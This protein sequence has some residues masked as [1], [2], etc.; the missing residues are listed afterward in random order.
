MG[1]RETGARAALPSWLEAMKGF[2]K[3]KK[4]KDFMPPDDIEW[5]VIDPKTGLL[6]GPDTESV[7]LEAFRVDTAPTEESPATET[8]PEESNKRFFELGR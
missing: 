1:R 6:P 4:K 5:V 8:S 3:G 7:F 2:H